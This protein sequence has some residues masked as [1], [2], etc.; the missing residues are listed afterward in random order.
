[1]NSTLIFKDK[2]KL[3]PRYLPNEL[4]H[5]E[6]EI[7]LLLQIY[8]FYELPD[9]ESFQLNISQIV[10]PTG[11]GKT[12]TVLLFSKVLESKCKKQGINL[13]IIYINLKLLGGNKY[14]I[15][16]YLMEKICPDIPPQG[17]SGEEMLKYILTFT[18]QNKTYVLI[19][20]DEIDYLLKISKEI[21][22]LYDLTRLNEFEPDYNCFIKGV[23][24]IARS[25]EFH[26]KIDSAE[27]STLGK[28]PIE[29][30]PYSVKELADIINKR[31]LESFNNGVIGSDV[32][33]EVALITTSSKIKGD[34]RYA[35]ELLLYTGNLI[36]ANGMDRIT[37]N[38]IIKVNS[39]IGRSYSL[40]DL[41][42]ISDEQIMVLQAI[43][44][45]IKY[46]KKNYIELKEIRKSIYE[47]VNEKGI[48]KLELEDT[49]YD[50]EKRDIIE[51]KSIKEIGLNKIS[52]EEAERIIKNNR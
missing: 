27:Q 3:S 43:T 39:K 35:L 46:K 22:I 49:I 40:E 21:G 33:D 6:K 25:R 10:G 12:S 31:C 8:N 29:F 17:L 14:I 32:I 36:D 38:D 37:I 47:L 11:I 42:E 45:T 52:I 16:K 15:Y 24:F 18:R 44:S 19:I 13:R 5:R 26:N 23:V 51:V 41:K 20:L 9:P 1:M 28:L 7:S 34:V 4:P 2:S 48:K 50:L 30:K